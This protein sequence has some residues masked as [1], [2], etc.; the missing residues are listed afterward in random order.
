MINPPRYDS[1]NFRFFREIWEEIG[2]EILKF[3]EQFMQ[4]S[5]LPKRINVTWM[6]LI[7]KVKNPI[8]L[9]GY[10]PIS[11]VGSMYNIIP[12]LLSI[13]LRGY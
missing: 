9:K 6:T 12:K 13:R 4:T 10:R 7:P 1:F 11:L 3:M 5:F 2:E 8:S